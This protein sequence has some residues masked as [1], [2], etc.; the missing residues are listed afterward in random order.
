MPNLTVRRPVAQPPGKHRDC[1]AQH[2]QGE[3][4]N[5]D[6]ADERHGFVSVTTSFVSVFALTVTGR[7]DR[8]GTATNKP[9]C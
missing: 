4:D 7:H 9:S 1:E 8:A 5:G 2:E 3:Q 6:V